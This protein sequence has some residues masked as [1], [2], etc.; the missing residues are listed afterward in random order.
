MMN[1][2]QID[3]SHEDGALNYHKST[4]LNRLDLFAH[5]RVEANDQCLYE[6][7]DHVHPAWFR[8]MFKGLEHKVRVTLVPSN[9]VFLKDD[10]LICHPE[11]AAE[12]DASFDAYTA[13][14]LDQVGMS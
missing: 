13:R 8:R 3:R 9:L 7:K 14:I 11:V 1:F 5:Y 2:G 6:Q 4:I 10:V 12:L